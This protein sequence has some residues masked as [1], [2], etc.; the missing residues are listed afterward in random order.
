MLLLR[1]GGHLAFPAAWV[2]VVAV[3]GCV[4]RFSRVLAG[5]SAGA[6]MVVAAVMTEIWAG[7]WAVGCAGGGLGGGA[8]GGLVPVPVTSDFWAWALVM[9]WE[10]AWSLRASGA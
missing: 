9:C 10:R 7:S 2:R 6:A 8:S 1:E 5:G 3:G 4:L